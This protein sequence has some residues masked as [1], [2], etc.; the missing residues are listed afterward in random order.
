ML[1]YSILFY[2][3]FILLFFTINRLKFS[4][5]KKQIKSILYISL[6][7]GLIIRIVAAKSIEGFPSDISCFK[8]WSIAAA[9]DIANFYSG[10]FF[11]DYPPMYIYILAAIGKVAKL[12][13]FAPHFILLVK[14]PAILADIA[15]SYILYKIAK[16]FISEKYGILFSLFYLFNPAVIINSALWGQIDSFFSILIMLALLSLI[17]KRIGLS[18]ALFA[19]SILIKPQGLIFLPVLFF[20]L[21]RQKNLKN[22]LVAF[23]YGILTAIVIIL[24]FSRDP[25]WIFKL[26]IKTTQGYEYAS[27]NAYNFFSVIGANLKKDYDTLFIFSYNNWGF[28]FI[29]LITILTGFFLIKNKKLNIIFLMS[30]FQISGV[31]IFSSR[32]HERYLFPAILLGLMA[33]LFVNDVRLLFISAAFSG[34]VY[35]NTYDVLYRMLYLNYPHIPSNDL[36]LLIFSTINVLLF[37]YTL[38]VVIDIVLADKIVKLPIGKES[39]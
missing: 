34:T 7:I 28:I 13:S 36:K 38:K 17:Y 37:I 16:K 32:M 3:F 24:P 8:A 4:I 23:A 5:T 25:L 15:S 10:K 9:E 22:F 33:S 31:F 11:C 19:V 12:Q 29:T 6:A 27:F 20:E 18:S 35:L 39:E 2:I 21:V 30:F 26:I 14:L 1:L